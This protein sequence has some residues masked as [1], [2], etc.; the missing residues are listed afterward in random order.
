[1]TGGIIMV[2]QVNREA[3]RRRLDAVPELAGALRE[4]AERWSGT[5]LEGLA[6]ERALHLAAEIV[7]DVGSDLIDGFFMRDAASYGDIVD[8]IAEEGVIGG[9]L[10]AGFR[11]LAEVRGQLIRSYTEWPRHRLHPLTAWLADGLERFAREVNA[12][13]EREL[14][15][16]V[17]K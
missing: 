6:Q 1:M 4:L 12:Y 7:T 3:I 13:L 9:D 15:P 11:E 14:G 8:I 17:A 10:A 2:Y 16:F 5:T